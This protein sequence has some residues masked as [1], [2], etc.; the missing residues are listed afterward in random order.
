M[1]VLITEEMRDTSVYNVEADTFGAHPKSGAEI[2][3]LF[4]RLAEEKRSRL[5][6]LSMIANEGV[7]FRNRRTEPAR[8]IEAALR[9]HITSEGRTI[10]LYADLL[11]LITKS[12]YKETIKAIISTER[13]TVASLKALQALVKQPV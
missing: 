11:K 7:G 4:T 13:G 10:S 5:K 2:V 6:T 1:R 8:S 3:K 9:N 12:E